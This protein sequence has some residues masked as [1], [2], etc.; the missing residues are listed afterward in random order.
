MAVI[1]K[2]LK[3]RRAG[4]AGL[5]WNSPNLA[6]K[7][8]LTLSSPDFENEGTIPAVHTAKR[9]GGKDPASTSASRS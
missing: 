5:A 1:G 9:V 7:D 4:H 3:A 8:L 2:L 6:G